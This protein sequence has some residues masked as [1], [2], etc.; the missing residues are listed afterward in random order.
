MVDEHPGTPATAGRLRLVTRGAG[1]QRDETVRAVPDRDAH[2]AA[3]VHRTARGDEDAFAELFEATAP[4]VLGLAKRIV[5]DGALAEEV[6][7]EVFV[8]VWRSATRFDDQRGTAR[9][10]VTTLA[11]RRAVDRVR[12]EQAHFDRDQRVA[13]RS[14][15]D[16]EDVATTA[17]AAVVRD[18]AVGRVRAALGTLTTLQREAI[19]LAF[20]R[21]YTYPEVARLLDVP[22]GTVKTRIRDGMIRLR[23]ELAVNT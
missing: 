3:L 2:E 17:V 12:A 6:T 9:G 11:H 5:R 19:E 4:A 23:D 7:Q 10:W 22:L 21:G 20:Y 15:N 16:D 14:P 1:G 8:E 13:A 18:L